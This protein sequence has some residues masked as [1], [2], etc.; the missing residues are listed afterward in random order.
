MSNEHIWRTDKDLQQWVK[1][2]FSHKPKRRQREIL[3]Y[4]RYVRDFYEAD[5]ITPRHEREARESPT[6]P[7]LKNF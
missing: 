1:D 6:K 3:E 4:M 7:V 2:M 5:G